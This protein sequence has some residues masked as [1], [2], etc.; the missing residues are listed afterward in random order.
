MKNALRLKRKPL[1]EQVIVVTGASSGIGLATAKMA[2][3]EGAKVVL[4]SRNLEDLEQIRQEI[5]A[6]G[7]NA[8]AVVADVSKV[9]DLEH[10]RD[11][12]LE[13][14]GRIDTWINN[15]GVSV[16]GNLMDLK[17]EDERTVFETNFWGIRNGSRIAVPELAKTNGV[18]INLG[19]E[20]SVRSIPLQGIYAASK[21]AVKAYTDALRM[22]LEH[23]EIPV[24]VSLIRPTA[25]ATPFPEH[26]KNSLR[27]GE[28]SL[29]NPMYHPDAVAA[30]IIDCVEHPRRDVFVG[31]VSRIQS[32]LEVVSPRFVDFIAEAMFFKEQSKGKGHSEA[33]EGLDHAPKKE[34][35]VRGK[36]SGI[37]LRESAYTVAKRKGRKSGESSDLTH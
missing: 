17:I 8:I 4:S 7:G 27:E 15:A 16:Y 19:S 1:A 35:N 9:E 29:P 14:Y 10:L 32:I 33:E 36:Q 11:A 31:A 18:L 23:D 34:G 20:V 30:A 25:I 6:A 24:A 26:A 28:P 37:V 12:A 21:H 13:G 5:T 22:E 2:A 3:K